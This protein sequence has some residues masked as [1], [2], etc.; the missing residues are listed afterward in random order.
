MHCVRHSHDIFGELAWTKHNSLSHLLSGS[1]AAHTT[2]GLV[3][4]AIV[5]IICLSGTLSVFREEIEN[6]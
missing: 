6:F 4:S 5:F 2:I 1:L 3:I